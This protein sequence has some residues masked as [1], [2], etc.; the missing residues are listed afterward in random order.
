MADADRIV[1]DGDLL[2]G[3][4]LDLSRIREEFDS[5]TTNSQTLAED[6]GHEWLG[7]RVRNFAAN[8]DF[9]RAELVEQLDTLS[10]NV[11]TVLDGFTE[12]DATLAS[13]VAGES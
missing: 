5:A 2:E 11:Q 8:W 7:E 9:R 4:I 12:A 1:I 6:V 13:S 10:G 3:M